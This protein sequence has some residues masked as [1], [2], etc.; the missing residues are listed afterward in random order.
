[1]SI[2]VAC[3]ACSRFFQSIYFRWWADQ[4]FFCFLTEIGD[5]PNSHEVWF[6]T[7]ELLDNKMLYYLLSTLGCRFNVSSTGLKTKKRHSILEK[8]M[9]KFVKSSASFNYCFIPSYYHSIFSILD[10][11]NKVNLGLAECRN[12]G[13]YPP[14][15]RWT[16]KAYYTKEKEK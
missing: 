8:P 6:P 12:L 2:S 1:M 11:Q 4:T 15:E 9:Y 10:W 7:V 5:P 3:L 16:K 13:F 14:A